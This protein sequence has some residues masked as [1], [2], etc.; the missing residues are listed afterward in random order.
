MEPDKA[1]MGQSEYS[2]LGGQMT[3]AGINF[4][5]RLYLLLLGNPTPH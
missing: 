2:V 4:N 5:F 3:K 1:I